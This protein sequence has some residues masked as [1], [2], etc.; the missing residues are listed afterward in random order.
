MIRTLIV[1]DDSLI[2]VTLRS[3]IDWESCGCTVVQDCSG[4]GQ[5]LGYLAEHPV[6]LLITDIKM[7]GMDGLE[8][9]RQLRRSGAMPVTVV[10][11]G[12]DE[13][14]LVREAF[15]LGAYDYLLKGGISQASLTQLLNGLRE[16]VFHSEGPATS[17]VPT[18]MGTEL[19]DGEYI[20]ALC[21]VEDFSQVSQR[22]GDNLRERMER[23]MLDPSGPQSPGPGDSTGQDP[24]SLR[25]VLPCPEPDRGA[26]Y[27][28]F[29]SPA[30]P[31]LVARPDEFGYGGRDQLRCLPPG[32]G[33][34]RRL[35]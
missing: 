35:L 24:L 25:A 15:R 10:L 4:G 30:D 29:G 9:M 14:E 33:G 22:F 20:L 26:G 6:D 19:E 34:S 3:L 18:G 11:S 21:V 8:L 2:H 12:Y 7:P 27:G 31:G 13:F 32:I 28:A 16:K 1:D 23:P 5:A 17:S